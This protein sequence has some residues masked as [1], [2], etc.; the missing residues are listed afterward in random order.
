LRRRIAQDFVNGQ[1]SSAL[2]KGF[3]ER[4]DFESIRLQTRSL[5]TDAALK[6]SLLDAIK[7]VAASVASESRHY[8]SSRS[9]SSFDGRSVSS[10]S[11]SK[12][13][14]APENS[15]TCSC[16]NILAPDAAFCRKCGRRRGSASDSITSHSHGSPQNRKSE[17]KRRKGEN[18]QG[19]DIFCACGNKFLDDAR[20]CRKCGARRMDM[21]KRESLSQTP[22]GQALMRGLRNGEVAGIFAQMEEDKAEKYKSRIYA[23]C[24]IVDPS[25]LQEMNDMFSKHAGK[26]PELYDKILIDHHILDDKLYDAAAVSMKIKNISYEALMEDSMVRASF[27]KAVSRAIAREAAAGASAEDV[28][29]SFQGHVQRELSA[30]AIVINANVTAPNK[31]L[32]SSIHSTLAAS[33]TLTSSVVLSLQDVLSIKNITSLEA[34]SAHPGEVLI[35]DVFVSSSEQMQAATRIQTVQRGKQVRKGVSRK[36]SIQLGREPSQIYQLGREPSSRIPPG[37][38]LRTPSKE[39][40]SFSES[41]SP[42]P[43]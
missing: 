33:T 12:A 16:G 11:S 7:T 41:N 27:E 17:P 1:L 36:K 15:D 4:K 38:G 8:R 43:V 20:F 22:A 30:G 26:E 21:K 3:E 37:D 32:A 18:K 14:V 9:V 2:S 35:T 19:K 28:N 40:A 39:S 25:K 13:H 6:G 5:V 23:I 34:G 31:V 42:V 29:L 24:S 10:R